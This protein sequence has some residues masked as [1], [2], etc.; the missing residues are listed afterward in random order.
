MFE[1][2]ASGAADEQPLFVTS[3]AKST[4]DWSRDGRF[5]LYGT[6]DPKTA[7]DLWALPMMGERK[8]FAVPP[9]QL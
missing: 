4:L 7:S 2:P 9:E 6:Q 3:Q 1:K 8:P 5:L